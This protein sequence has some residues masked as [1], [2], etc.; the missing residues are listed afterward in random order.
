[1]LLPSCTAPDPRR[2]AL[3]YGVLASFPIGKRGSLWYWTGS[4][5]EEVQYA[6]LVGFPV[7]V[8]CIPMDGAGGGSGSG[9]V[10]GFQ[11]E[12]KQKEVADD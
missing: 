11:E 4:P 5:R 8:A 9:R 12:Q 7:D 1:M 3:Q 2:E 10:P 6:G